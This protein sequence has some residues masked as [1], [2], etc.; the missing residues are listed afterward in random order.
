MV[1]GR[2]TEMS[3]WVNLA[4]LFESLPSSPV[5]RGLSFGLPGG[6]RGVGVSPSASPPDPTRGLAGHA[7]PPIPLTKCSK[8]GT[9]YNKTAGR[10][11]RCRSKA[12]AVN[13]AGGMRMSP[14]IGADSAACKGCGKP[15]RLGEKCRRCG[16]EA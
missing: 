12:E 6:M 1:A 5:V 4:D 16:M 13:I 3:K 2:K 14:L 11:P 8:C 7:G 15:V 9:A 10:C